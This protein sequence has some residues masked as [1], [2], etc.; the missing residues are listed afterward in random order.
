M[1]QKLFDQVKVSVA[2]IISVILIITGLI[3]QNLYFLGF[4]VV[5]LLVI[6]G[7]SNI[8]LFWGAIKIGDDKDKSKKD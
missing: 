7:I 6:L 2:F 8:N 5:I 4:G 1:K 3:F